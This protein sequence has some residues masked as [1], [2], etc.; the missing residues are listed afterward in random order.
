[1]SALK[2]VMRPINNK[3]YN[4]LVSNE[5][6]PRTKNIYWGNVT[7]TNTDGVKYLDSGTIVV[8]RTGTTTMQSMA[9]R[10][11]AATSFSAN[12]TGILLDYTTENDGVGA[13][14]SKATV[15]TGLLDTINSVLVTT[16]TGG[17]T[18]TGISTTKDLSSYINGT[19]GYGNSIKFE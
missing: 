3:G 2:P 4:W 14:V 15:R 6:I 18:L 19:Y 8:T 13:I 1:M 11:A 16:W 7:A 17:G 5:S 12:E 9:L 10:S